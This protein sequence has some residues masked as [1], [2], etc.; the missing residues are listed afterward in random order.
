MNDKIR[1]Y[2]NNKP[3]ELIS[4]TIEKNGTRAIDNAVIVM[5]RKVPI[6]KG[7]TVTYLQDVVSTKYLVGFWNFMNSTRDEG[8][9]DLDGNESSSL[10]TDATY[11]EGCD[12]S[13]ISF[14][15]NETKAV[16]IDDDT[17]TLSGSSTT[18]FNFAGQFDIIIWCNIP[19]LSNKNA[20][21]IFSKGDANDFI[22]ISHTA[23]TSGNVSYA[24]VELKSNGGSTTTITGSNVNLVTTSTYDSSG[25]HFIRVKRDEN[26]LVTLSVDGTSEGTATLT[27]NIDTSG[28]YLYIGADESGANFPHIRIANIRF[29]SGSYLKDDE[30]TIVKESRRMPNIMK[31]GGE[32]W[33]ID[34]KPTFKR[35]LVHG[36]AKKLHEHIIDT[37]TPSPNFTT[38]DDG[39]VK[40]IYYDKSA[41]FIIDDMCKIFNDTM[42]STE[43][44]NI[45]V[46]DVDNNV[47]QTYT[48][49]H[50]RGSIFTNLVILV[51]NGNTDSSFSI[52]ARKVLRLEDDDIDYYSGGGTIAGN[53]TISSYNHN[54]FSPITFKQGVIRVKD[55]G[56]DTSST[57]TSVT[58][59]TGDI[60]TYE[61]TQTYTQADFEEEGGTDSN[62]DGV[63]DHGYTNYGVVLTRK[64]LDDPRRL[65]V[66]HSADGALDYTPMSFLNPDGDNS[67]F[68]IDPERKMLFLGASPNSGNVTITYDYE[69]I[70]TSNYRKSQGGDLAT[71]GELDR[72]LYVPQLR[73]SHGTNN[74]V[75]FVNRFISRHGSVNRRVTVDSP[76]LIN[77][78]RENY[79]V[80]V[81]DTTHGID[82]VQNIS[83][84]SMVYEYPSGITHINLGDHIFDSY[85]LD[86]V[87]GDSLF[88][89]R[90]TFTAT[91]P[92]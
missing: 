57:V 88:E 36:Y 14:D 84:R 74:I 38:G 31:F 62:G 34:E 2:V 89:L 87:Y 43:S 6:T 78:V 21:Y 15:G 68:Y 56:Y 60:K 20:G 55:L 64:P 33:K 44:N 40:N 80:K 75:N 5:P 49:Y 46:V 4:A 30:Y 79:K 37:A 32:V 10:I 24:K 69:D 22:K 26:G 27:G 19:F 63:P 54:M 61:H 29:Y 39:I 50:A 53:G 65:T 9:Y 16:R 17:S 18:K 67:H 8:G 71:L 52:D 90:N 42:N 59:I 11:D 7:D 28:N 25:Y 47:T 92:S 76:T 41:A 51:T 13:V 58:A 72:V 23:I 77:H 48:E 3:R 1:C 82:T 70:S 35:V 45:R 81:I 91:Q 66:T 12:G 86:K 73:A 83:V 85:D